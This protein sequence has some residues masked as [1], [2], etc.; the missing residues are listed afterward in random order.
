MAEAD[1]LPVSARAHATQCWYAQRSPFAT[2]SHGPERS[3]RSQRLFATW[4]RL[5]R[6][7]RYRRKGSGISSRPRALRCAPPELPTAASCL[8][9]VDVES[10][11]SPARY[12]RSVRNRTVCKLSPTRI[13]ISSTPLCC[14]DTAS[15]MNEPPWRPSGGTVEVFRMVSLYSA[16]I[17]SAT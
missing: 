10:E 1:R 17:A 11:S 3:P 13:A 2:P 8:A 4:H 6:Q 12:N 7:P 5:Q 14:G 15:M 16:S 9:P